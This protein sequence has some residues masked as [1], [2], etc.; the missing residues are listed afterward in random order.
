[1]VFNKRWYFIKF[2]ELPHF[3]NIIMKWRILL[4]LWFLSSLNSM[5]IEK[6]QEYHFDDDDFDTRH[7]YGNF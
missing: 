2:Q 4:C 7:L 3:K 6:N 5:G 1:M